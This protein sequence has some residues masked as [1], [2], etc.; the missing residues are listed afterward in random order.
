MVVSRR[1]TFRADTTTDTT[2]RSRASALASA[3]L[4]TMA[5]SSASAEDVES[6][7]Q[8][9][10]NGPEEFRDSRSD[11]HDPALIKKMAAERRLVD[12]AE[13]L[14][15]YR[16]REATAQANLER[17]RAERV[18]REAAGPAPAPATK[19]RRKIRS[20]P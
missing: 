16:A 12:A 18:A 14:A 9:L 19:S 20:R 8:R 4:D 1:R 13:G 2:Q 6:R 3:E 7:K 5:D 10:L 15:A 17:L 11:R